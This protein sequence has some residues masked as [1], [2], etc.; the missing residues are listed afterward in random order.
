MEENKNNPKKLW[1]QIKSLGYSNKSKSSPTLFYILIMRIAMRTKRLQIILTLFFTTVASVLVQKLPS[2]SQLFSTSS[3]ILKNF[4]EIRNSNSKVFRLHTLSEE[5]VLKEMGS[6]N[7]FKKYRIGQYLSKVSKGW[8]SIFEI[9]N[10]IYNLY[11]N[12]KWGS[13]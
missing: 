8:S 12:Y 9:A 13:S 7:S 1:E 10:H 5:F 6:L 3:E 2:C 11:V 4:Y